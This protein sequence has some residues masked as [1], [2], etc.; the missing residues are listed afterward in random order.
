MTV[1]RQI[2][3]VSGPYRSKYGLVG[4]V[5]NIW[6]AYQAGRKLVKQGY[7]VYIPH[8][9]TCLMDGLQSEE[10]FL[11]ATLK[12]LPKCQIIYMMKGWESSTGAKFEILEA[13]YR[14]LQIMYEWKHD[15]YKQFTPIDIIET[16]LRTRIVK[17]FKVPCSVVGESNPYPAVLD[18]DKQGISSLEEFRAL[19]LAKK[20]DKDIMSIEDNGL[21]SSCGE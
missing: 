14:H 16:Y 17:K 7:S 12:M 13:D 18:L 2:V 8:M 1:K 19:D 9:N 5:I 21:D 10:W 4:R 15:Y 11:D 6:K 20:I 3:F